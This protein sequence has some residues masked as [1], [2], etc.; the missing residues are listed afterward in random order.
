LAIWTGSTSAAVPAVDAALGFVQDASIDLV[1][2]LCRSD[3]A[4]TGDRAVI[5]REMVRVLRPVT[6]V[7]TR[8]DF[9]RFIRTKSL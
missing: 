5:V 1:K 7:R 2:L 6:I 9:Q 4:D 3:E 8:L